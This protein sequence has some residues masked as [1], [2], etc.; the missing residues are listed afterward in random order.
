MKKIKQ[1]I[2]DAWKRFVAFLK[3]IKDNIKAAAEK[4]KAKR[5]QIKNLKAIMK[6]MSTEDIKR[7]ETKMISDIDEKAVEFIANCCENINISEI[8]ACNS[9][10]EVEKVKEEQVSKIVDA[11][12]VSASS[13]TAVVPRELTPDMLRKLFEEAIGLN[14]KIS[15]VDKYK[16][17][18]PVDPSR[19]LVA[20]D[21]SAQIAERVSKSATT[22]IDKY[23]KMINPNDTYEDY[24][25]ETEKANL[26]RFLSNIAMLASSVTS[27][28][29]YV[30]NNQVLVMEEGED[31]VWR[32]TGHTSLEEA[33]KLLES[34]SRYYIIA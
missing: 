24:K 17:S 29:N 2:I 20:V 9:V 15:Y 10:E 30:L 6:N 33:V 34:G 12:H 32:F 1:F 13:S 26:L 3:K 14:K 22:A 27:K 31:G 21:K 19:A 11:A 25:T 5:T 23:T 8:E 7:L 28:A 18:D 16:D 4:R